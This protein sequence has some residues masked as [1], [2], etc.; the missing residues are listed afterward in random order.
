MQFLLDNAKCAKLLTEFIEKNP[1]ASKEDFDRYAVS[2]GLI[3]QPKVAQKF[4][5][6][7]QIERKRVS[8]VKQEIKRQAKR[9]KEEE[10]VFSWISKTGKKP[11][12]KLELNLNY[13][14]AIILYIED[15]ED[16][17]A[18]MKNVGGFYQNEQNYN[19][20]DGTYDS[21]PIIVVK[22]CFDNSGME[23]EHDERV[24]NKLYHEV[25]HAR[26]QSVIDTL[27]VAK[28]KTVW[29][30]LN[31]S[32]H[33][34]IT[35]GMKISESVRR[36]K[37]KKWLDLEEARK[38]EDW[39]IV[40]DAALFS[41]K[42]ELLAEFEVKW[43]DVS[44]HKNFLKKRKGIYDYFLNKFGIDPKSELYEMIWQDYE[45]IIEAANKVLVKIQ[46]GYKL[47]NFILREKIKIFR[48]VL[49]QIPIQDWQKQ[50]E[51]TLF[52][53]EI[54]ELQELSK[55]FREEIYTEENSGKK[56]SKKILLASKFEEELR[57]KPDNEPL[58]PMIR[59]FKH[60]IAE[61]GK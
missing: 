2:T 53:E 34:S 50:M 14:L 27:K 16:F 49:I 21:F 56:K 6:Q 38:S 31:D 59:E 41:A 60:D 54:K 1:T 7:L 17:S 5:D 25:G 42:D 3:S 10:I 15:S 33:G 22:G 45:N 36:L 19:Q 8:K 4:I 35:K 61:L 12:G 32:D 52:F 9:G 44:G 57:A 43:F 11:K 30:R 48:W 58:L 51:E 28:R 24:A 13:P 39:N 46:E 37:S 26:N 47:G 40:L 20:N 29:S 55:F 23:E 18:V